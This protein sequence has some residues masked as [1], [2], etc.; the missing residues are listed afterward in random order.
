MTKEEKNLE[1]NLALKDAES[2]LKFL[3]IASNTKSWKP[4]RTHGGAILSALYFVQKAKKLIEL[5]NV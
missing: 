5:K 3:A 2:E 4:S 1:L